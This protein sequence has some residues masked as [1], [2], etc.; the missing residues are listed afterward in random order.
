MTKILTLFF[1]NLLTLQVFAQPDVEWSDTYGGSFGDIPRTVLAI[2]GGGYLVAG[3]TLSDDDDI[4]DNNGKSDGWLIR[5]DAQGGLLWERS[6]GG[7]L[8]DEIKKIIPANDGG[9]IIAGYQSENTSISTV[10]RPTSDFWVAKINDTGTI[11]WTQ[12]FGS[13]ESESIVDIAATNDGYLLL[14]NSNNPG[15]APAGYRGQSDPVLLKINNSGEQQWIRRWGG[16]QNDFSTGLHIMNNG[17]IV[18]SG[19]ADSKYNNHHGA[20]DGWLTYLNANGNLVWTKFFGGSLDD[21]L[22]SVSAGPGNQIYAAGFS[23]SKDQDL[24]D[25]KGRRDAWL[26]RVNTTGDLLWSANY[27]GDGHDAFNKV[28]VRNNSV[29]AAGYTWSFDGT[30]T[31]SQGLKDAWLTNIDTNGNQNWEAT[32]GGDLSEELFSFDF[33]EDNG[34]L[35]AGP[36]QTRY[37]GMVEE[38]NG[39]EDFFLIRLAGS[40]PA[41]ISV[42]AGG[43]RTIC[44]GTS[45]N[46]TANISNCNGCVLTWEDQTTSATRTVSP[47]VTTTYTV[48]ITDADGISV[49]DD[50]TVFVSE[51]PTLTIDLTGEGLCPG[52]PVILNTSTQNCEGCS[53]QWNDGNT[54]SQR[55]L[56]VEDDITYS[57]TI[58]NEDGCSTS[59]SIAVPVM[60]MINFTGITSPVTCQGDNDGQITINNNSGNTINFAWSNGATG[61]T[62]SNLAAGTYTVTAG[63]I[64]FCAEVETY[65]ITEPDEIIFNASTTMVSCNNQN[66]GSISTSTG[67]GIPPYDFAWSNGAVTASQNNLSAGSYTVTVTD[68]NGCSLIEMV[69]ITQPDAIQLSTSRTA[70]SCHGASDGAITV[71]PFGGAGNYTFNWNNGNTTNQLTG[72]SAG[73]YLVAVTDG[74]GCSTTAS[75][76]LEEPLELDFNINAIPPTSGDNGSILAVPFGGTPPYQLEWNTG[77][78]S[79]QIINLTEGTYSVT[80]T[81]L[82]GCTGEEEI[83][84]GL[85]SN[86]ALANLD[87]FSI[88][89][90]PNSGVFSVKIGLGNTSDFSLSLVNTLGQVIQKKE[91][92]TGRLNETFDFTDLASGV[93]YVVFS[94]QQGVRVKPV[95]IE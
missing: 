69:E 85:T 94:D 6:F 45:V 15:F 5:I 42:S 58:T 7:E 43:D 51:V 33:T 8:Q 32:Y 3:L 60:E 90:N 82:N 31:P 59:G 20:V 48:T 4:S 26:I 30:A 55:T 44:N 75:F 80:V 39:L 35:L 46:L 84:L 88:F 56:I 78:T 34:L 18:V 10:A 27:G 64:G 68:A 54:Q 22:N 49:S 25:N 70:I 50:V 67:G 38:N 16:A 95:V 62:I 1:L 79:F 37:N 87:E 47:T 86:E 72:L 13:T 61:T 74:D 89:P 93:Y 65:Q 28:I 77:S 91:F 66:N 52:D 71:N 63:A 40:G 14:G 29:Y 9:Y 76:L 19:Y 73:N 41:E 21:Q 24:S 92:R 12:N 11:I 36:T 83:F 23:Y 17:R 2:P 57:L 53:F 81:D